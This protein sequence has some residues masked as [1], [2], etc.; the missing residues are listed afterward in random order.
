MIQVVSVLGAL[1]ILFAYTANQFG[2][3]QTAGVVYSLANA[4]G[5]AVLTGV[6]AVERQWGFLLLEGVWMLVSLAA[7]AHLGRERKRA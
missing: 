6:A 1:M 4:I 7:L 2:Q 3:L 5:A